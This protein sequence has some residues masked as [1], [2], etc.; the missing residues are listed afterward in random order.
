ME[1][2]HYDESRKYGKKVLANYVTYMWILGQ[3]ISIFNLFEDLTNPI[4]T[5]KFRQ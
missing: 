4:K 3:P 2:V 5:D 1:L